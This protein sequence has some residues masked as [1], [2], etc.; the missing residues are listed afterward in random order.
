MANVPQDNAL[1]QLKKRRF[2]LPAHGMCRLTLTIN[3]T[4]YGVKPIPCD[5]PAAIKAFRLRKANGT[6]YDVAQT[7]HGLV[8]DCPDFV[9]HRDGIDEAGCKHI[10]ALVALG[11]LAK[12]GGAK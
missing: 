8:C 4:E 7:T 1:Q 3:G 2:V 6:A 9:F 10:K 5:P 12:E 11:M